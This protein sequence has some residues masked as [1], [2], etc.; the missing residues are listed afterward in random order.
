MGAGMRPPWRIKAAL[1]VGQATFMT[2]PAL[3]YF[4]DGRCGFG[5]VGQSGAG[6]R[7]VSTVPSHSD[8]QCDYIHAP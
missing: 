7:A 1:P 3:L 4:T 5:P 8:V 6:F 2:V